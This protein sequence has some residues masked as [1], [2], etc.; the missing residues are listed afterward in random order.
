MNNSVS[1]R[2]ILCVVFGLAFFLGGAVPVWA[3]IYPLGD[4]TEDSRLSDEYIPFATE[5]D[6]DSGFW[7]EFIPFKTPVGLPGRPSLL[8]EL[9][10]PFLDTGNLAH[11][12][13][14]PGG[15]VWRP[16][17]QIFGTLRTVVQTFD[18]GV[19]DRVSEWRNRLD[20][21]ANL[22]LTGTEKILVGIRPLDEN[23]F[24]EF[25][26]CDLGSNPDKR[27]N[28]E[29]FNANIRTLFFEGDFGSLF[30]FLDPGGFSK[31]DYGFTVGRQ[32]FVFQRGMLVNDVIDAV[33]IV[34]NNIRLPG[35]SNLRVSA[36]WGWNEIDRPGTPPQRGAGSARR[37]NKTAQMFG[38]F[39][40][41]DTEH[42][43]FNL[44][45]IYIHDKGPND[46]SSRD[47]GSGAYAGLSAI[48][49]IGLINTAFRVNGS[50]ARQTDTAQVSD[51]V[52]ISAEISWTAAHADDIV[53]INPFGTIG[54][55]TQS[56][57]ESVVG[58]PL[59]GLGILFA[60]PSLGNFGSELNSFANEVVGI[61]MGYQAFWQNH[62][63]SLNLEIAGRK[64]QNKDD[65][66]PDEAGVG[67]E[68]RQRVWQ[69][70]QMQV[71]GHYT[72]G[73]D[74]DNGYGGRLE[75]LIQF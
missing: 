28:G 39:N 69:H 7:E 31:L 38:L 61:A 68:F 33:G 43:T 49:R 19:A 54:T 45:L 32:S 59:G 58:G 30:P 26:G 52:L 24:N 35:I 55:F 11:G 60:S 51:G 23:R 67:F 46:D 41:A 12:F 70:V 74:R 48:Q 40:S 21:Y 18:N 44:D 27:C 75:F 10:D 17:L 73:E 15:A 53:Y 37:S 63:R 36:L 57:R 62:R 72:I 1:K 22:Q 14:L 56:S 64:D 29:F 4:T 47:S 6:E 3:G 65:G 66:S 34:R 20:L 8:F 2:Q 42:H 16:R 9:G 5:A 50:L 71:D 25:S 13:E